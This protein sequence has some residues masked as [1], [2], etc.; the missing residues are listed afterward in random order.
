MINNSSIHKWDK[1]KQKQLDTQFI[2]RL[3]SGM[4]CSMF[5]DIALFVNQ[6]YAEKHVNLRQKIL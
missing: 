4:N 3:Q 1:L 6:Y 2:N 5:K